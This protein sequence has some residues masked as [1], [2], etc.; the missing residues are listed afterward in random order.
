MS[1]SK[2]ACTIHPVGS[3]NE[4]YGFDKTFCTA[5]SGQ[6]LKQ[7]IELTPHRPPRLPRTK[8]Q[9][10]EWGS[11]PNAAQEAV[12]EQ[13]GWVVEDLGVVG[14]FLVKSA[15]E[16]DIASNTSMD[17]FTNNLIAEAN[18]DLGGQFYVDSAGVISTT[19]P[20]T[21]GTIVVDDIDPRVWA[22]GQ[23][24]EDVYNFD[25][26][27]NTVF[28]NKGNSA[29]YHSASDAI[30]IDCGA[31][32]TFYTVTEEAYTAASEAEKVRMNNRQQA[33]LTRASLQVYA[34]YQA[35]RS[36]ILGSSSLLKNTPLS[37]VCNLIGTSE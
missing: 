7:L 21:S 18:T 8:R 1:V 25:E 19:H 32:A 35:W 31:D 6:T 4:S 13:N 12:I 28:A 30:R 11:P 22:E 26:H 20:G 10:S 29:S 14:R 17:T 36:S 37:E 23:D 3:E 24:Y 9:I 2:G 27:P 34:D 16:S 5:H 33:S 15:S